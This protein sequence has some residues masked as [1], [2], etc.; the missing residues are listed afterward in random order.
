MAAPNTSGYRHSTA[1]ALNAPIEAPVA[2]T[3][4]AWPPRSAWIAGTTSHR[5][6]SWNWL[7]SHIRCSG[8]PAFA[9]IARPA[10]LSTEYSLTRPSA[11][12]GPQASTR[13]NRSTSSAS[14]PADGKT[15]TGR[16]NVPHRTTVISCWTRSE[17]HRDVVFT[18][19]SGGS[20]G[21]QAREES[22]AARS[23]A[24]FCRPGMAG[25]Q[26]EDGL[27]ERGFLRPAAAGAAPPAC[28]FPG[29]LRQAGPVPAVQV[30][31]RAPV[32][33][34]HPLGVLDAQR[35]AAP[36]QDAWSAGVRVVVARHGSGGAQPLD[37]DRL[38]RARRSLVRD[39]RC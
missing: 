25:C 15:R 30:A 9:I 22:G 12:S 37:G 17:Y 13:W 33:A 5:T 20:P 10:T 18:L 23:V 29:V 21:L 36:G 27:A 4:M 14:P 35:R 11:S 6:H 34:L 2:I 1:T 16:P 28:G 7:S 39:F 32:G 24:G 38:A 19:T 31:A 3:S 26:R 8:E